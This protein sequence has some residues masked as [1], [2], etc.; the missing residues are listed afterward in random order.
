MVPGY[1]ST[2]SEYSGNNGQNQLYGDR[3]R[4][5]GRGHGRSRQGQSSYTQSRHTGSGDNDDPNDDYAANRE[6]RENNCK[7]ISI[8]HFSPEDE[9]QDFLVWIGQFEQVINT[10][11]N[12]HSRRRHHNYCLHWLPTCLNGEAYTTWNGCEHKKSN[13]TALKE[14]LAEKFEDPS[15]RANWQTDLKAYT[16]D[17]AKVP[18]H[19]YYTKVRRLVD[20]LEP[21]M[22]SCPKVRDNTYYT[23]FVCGLPDDYQEHVKLAI[24]TRKATIDK[25]L[26]VVTRYQVVKNGKKFQEA[27]VGASVTFQDPNTP[28]RL[29]AAESDIL[30]LRNEMKEI[31][32]NSSSRHG[33]NLD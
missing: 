11:I 31:K 24:T 3:G 5:C 4:G 7:S 26:E 13:W 32:R 15:I 6:K 2:D 12:P 16:W 27:E 22:S 29:M 25:A 17:E 33:N 20:T 19:T 18:I 30:W 1:D 8:K 9:S 10:S 28:A 23:R 21:D 14:Y